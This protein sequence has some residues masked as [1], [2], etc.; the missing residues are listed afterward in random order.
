MAEVKKKKKLKK[1]SRKPHDPLAVFDQGR[2]GKV[3]IKKDEQAREDIIRQDKLKLAKRYEAIRLFDESVKYYRQIGMDEEAERVLKKRDE[4]YS[5]KA[6][7]F[8]SEGRYAEAAELYER[9][10]EQ[11]KANQMRRKG[12]IKDSPP[13]SLD[14][15]YSDMEEMEEVDPHASSGKMETTRNVRW[16]MPNVEME[17][18]G[19]DGEGQA[20]PGSRADRVEPTGHDE[21]EKEPIPLSTSQEMVKSAEKDEK[22]TEAVESTPKQPGRAFSICPC[23]GEELNLPKQPK[24]CPYCREALA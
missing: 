18:L 9:M 17:K 23:C 5:N 22:E 3:A 20:V 12:G 21:D 6:E 8:A 1:K 7:E 15:R 16:E 13:F 24:F 14:V 10:N 4:L 2:V 11:E 19:R